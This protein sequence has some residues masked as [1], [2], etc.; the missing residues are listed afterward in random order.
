MV[1]YLCYRL[2]FG[3]LSVEDGLLLAACCEELLLCVS[4]VVPTHGFVC[5]SLKLLGLG[6][7]S[8]SFWT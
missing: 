7:T 5:T 2:I 6:S 4:Y 1:C 3:L 8:A